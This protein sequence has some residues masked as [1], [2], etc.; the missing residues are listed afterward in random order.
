MLKSMLSPVPQARDGTPYFKDDLVNSP[1]ATRLISGIESPPGL[2]PS[3][4]PYSRDSLNANAHLTTPDMK[5]LQLSIAAR[6]S[7]G[8]LLISNSGC[9]VVRVKT[10]SPPPAPSVHLHKE[11][12]G[13][14]PD[15]QPVALYVLSNANGMT[16]KLSAYGA[17]LTELRVPDRQGHSASVVHGF[18]NL[19][20]Y[21]GSHPAFGCTVGRY[22]NRIAQ[23]RFSI[24]GVA[25]QVTP[26]AAPHHI[27]GGRDGFHRKLW[28][29]QPGSVRAEEASVTFTYV[30]PDGEEGYPGTLTAQVTYTLTAD[31]AL[32]IDYRATT[33]KATVV[34]LT[35]HSYFNLAG[36]GDI[37]GHELMIK[38]ERYTVADDALIP[39]GEIASV[40]GTP[41]DFGRPM[42]IGARIE[43]LKPKPGGYDHNY[44]LSGAGDRVRLAA[45]LFE[46]GSGRVM[47]VLTTEPGMQLY[48]GNF[49]DGQHHGPG[50]IAYGKHS[51]VCFETQHY[52]DSPNH[53]PFPSTIL[54][55][56]Q[57]FRSATIYR[58][59][60]QP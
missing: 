28:Q 7:L 36:A 13:A 53:V 51:G 50:G 59:T 26:N 58:F 27:H 11:S 32:R 21:L 31:N 15:G 48:T 56:G 44:V 54:R 29:V 34:N 8:L 12:F 10:K 20:S 39:T 30:S 5:R 24:D 1:A 46:P 33:D 49:L 9:I 60:V 17:I 18:D 38:A 25:Y 19:Q 2:G 6:L 57:T 40:E 52:P 14:M 35:N 23:A 4:R 3:S 47:E 42:T 22:A 41:L 45:R 16:V 37:L 43:Q 55:P